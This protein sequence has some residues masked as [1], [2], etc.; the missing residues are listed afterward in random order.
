MVRNKRRPHWM[1]HNK[2]SRY[3]ARFVCLD[4]ETHRQRL[5]SGERQTFRLAYAT[6][7]NETSRSGDAVDELAFADTAE[8]WRWIDSKT[9]TKCRTFVF[10][11]NLA[12]D[13]RASS[14]LVNLARIGWRVQSLAL[15]RHRCW[16][17][18]T[19]GN[20]TL[21]LIDTVSFLGVALNKLADEVKWNYV[22]LPHE[23]SSTESF[24]DRCR[25]DTR[26]LRLLVIRMLR[27]LGDNDAGD[28]R[29]TGPAQGTALFRHRFLPPN[30][31][32]IHDDPDLLDL[33]RKAGWAGRCEVWKHGY[34]K[35]PLYE[36]DFSLCY[37]RTAR[38]ASL[39][40]RFRCEVP[41]SA[42]DVLPTL[43]NDRAYLAQVRIATDLPIVPA[44]IDGRICWPI[45]TFDTVLWD[46]EIQLARDFGAE[47]EIQRAFLYQASPLMKEW[48]DWI[49]GRLDGPEPETCPVGRALLKQW[50][51]STVGRFGL[52]YP[53][54]EQKDEARET[55]F[56]IVPWIDA[57][58]KATGDTLWIGNQI[59][60]RSGVVESNDSAPAIMSYVMALARCRL[61]RAIATLPEGSLC[62]CDTDSLIVTEQGNDALRK[63]AHKRIGEGLRV[64]AKHV[65]ATFHAPR[66]VELSGAAHF[67]GL[68][69]NATPLGNGRYRAVLWEGAESSLRRRD[70]NSILLTERV[71]NISPRDER[72][73]HL[74]NGDTAPRVYIPSESQPTTHANSPLPIVPQ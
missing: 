23:E 35:G 26:L 18:M 46:C 70:P 62:Y 73:T 34:V 1:R 32:L 45:G 56:A 29:M 37:A 39:P 65:D 9:T 36:W 11:H 28:F 14:A 63:F 16:L 66:A 55:G 67:A 54:W 49:I 59:L 71:F 13:L 27:W 12:F 48:G 10:A 40:T 44:Y 8:L 6:F 5:E 41:P 3:P 61:W 53:L 22:P 72:R 69:R 33:E 21:I 74:S 47:V 51:R 2:A 68:P 38:M 43:G 20:R 7:D 52:R 17:R 57:E 58:T 15:D 64:K 42:F 24:L 30:G 60:E 4:V 31:L 19:R 25:S 50:S